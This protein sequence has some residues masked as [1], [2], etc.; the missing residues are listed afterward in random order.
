MS[1]ATVRPRVRTGQHGHPRLDGDRA[2]RRMLRV[3]RQAP[4]DRMHACDRIAQHVHRQDVVAGLP[5]DHHF[6]PA[7]AG[8]LLGCDGRQ[9][10]RL[11]T[12]A[13]ARH[14]LSLL[15]EPGAGVESSRAFVGKTEAADS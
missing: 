3:H 4:A 8:G 1:D 15:S 7:G 6:G 11:G 12:T 5:V 2:T 14:E 10:G 9:V 13:P